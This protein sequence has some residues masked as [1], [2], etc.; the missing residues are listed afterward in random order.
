VCPTQGAELEEFTASLF[1]SAPSVLIGTPDSL[2]FVCCEVHRRR[3][4]SAGV[5]HLLLDEEAIFPFLDLI[6]VDEV[7]DVVVP[8]AV[9]SSSKLLSALTRD[10]R[11]EAK[12]QVVFVSATMGPSIMSHIQA[13]MK[14]GAFLSHADRI[15]E[16]SAQV[17]AA[18][19]KVAVPRLNRP[20]PQLTTT[21]YFA[22]TFEEQIASIRLTL[23]AFPLSDSLALLLIPH[24]SS[25]RIVNKFR[26]AL[27]PYELHED[28][29]L[30]QIGEQNA[31]LVLKATD[32]SGMD[33]ANVSHVFVLSLPKTAA[34]WVH[35]IGRCGRMGAKGVAATV[36]PRSFGRTMSAFAE[37]VDIPFKVTNRSFDPF[38]AR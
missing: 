28:P 18:N 27:S 33:I 19:T 2:W 9:S 26:K 3:C 31:F 5:E 6:V 11:S 32:I 4:Q 20:P 10:A 24:D 22:D 38:F 34:E 12:V 7:S 14:R 15:L 35:W 17:H 29:K 23:K 1:D 30:A 16:G 8:H 25:P 36:I 21:F 37:A 13:Y